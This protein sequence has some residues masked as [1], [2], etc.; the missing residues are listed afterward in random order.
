MDGLAS[1]DGGR[2]YK[3]AKRVEADMMPCGA[4]AILP[5]VLLLRTRSLPETLF[6]FPFLPGQSVAIVC[7]ILILLSFDVPF[8]RRLGSL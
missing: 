8:K 1:N 5:R 4:V 7:G 2:G 6:P 3:M